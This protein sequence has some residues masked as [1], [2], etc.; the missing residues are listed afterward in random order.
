MN[1]KDEQ[2]ILIKQ[3]QDKQMNVKIKNKDDAMIEENINIR[4]KLNEKIIKTITPSRNDQNNTIIPNNNEN[5][6]KNNLNNNNSKNNNQNESANK[7]IDSNADK[8][9]YINKFEQ[10]KK[11]VPDLIKYFR[12]D[13]ILEI[14]SKNNG[15]LQKTS[16]YLFNC[17][18]SHQKKND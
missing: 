5:T 18:I 10:L 1:V 7:V 16:D 9:K 15:D 3:E 2:R 11:D 4:N 8:E 6:I 17:L 14:L 12:K 13:Y